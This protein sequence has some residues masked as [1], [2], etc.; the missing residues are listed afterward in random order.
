MQINKK[1]RGFTLSEM[2]VVL[3]V[4]TIVMG[5]AFSVLNLVQRHMTGI[6]R[7]FKNKTELQK[8]EQTLYLD[9]NRYP[10]IEYDDLK[11]KLTF[12]SELEEAVYLFQDRFII[13]ET[14]TFNVP[15][16][17]KQLFFNGNKINEGVVDAL[18]LISTKE[19]RNS[20]LF[21]FKTNDA[22]HFVN[23]GL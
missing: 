2:V 19:Y 9:F 23:H 4:T 22:T 7:N 6:Q 21:I 13:K 5:L 11:N 12:K 3:I 1:I 15:T 16:Q 8:L 20:A 17:D 10:N 18:K 14:D